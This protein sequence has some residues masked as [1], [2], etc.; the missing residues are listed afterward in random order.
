MKFKKKEVHIVLEFRWILLLC[1]MKNLYLCIL[2][3]FVWS[4]AAQ[5][6]KRVAA[7]N[8]TEPLKID[9]V[10]DEKVYSQAQPAQDFFQLQPYNGSPSFQKSEVKFFYD[11][12]SIYVGAMLSDT[13]PDSIFNFMTQ[14][15]NIGMSDYF[16]VYFDPYNKG[17]LAF[18]FFIT[19]AGVQTDIKAT[20]NEGD[21]E[22]ENWNAVWESK[23]RIVENGWI[24]EMKI[25]Y[26]ALRF[27]KN[28]E[29]LWGLN[30]FRNIRRHNSNNSWNFIDRK[31]SGFIHQ[32]G[33]L[34]GIKNIKS[35]VRLSFTP[36]AASYYEPQNSQNKTIFKGGMDVKYGLNDAFTLDMMLIPDFG[37]I[38]SDDQELN[39]SPYEIHYNE[40]RQFFTEGTELFQ[41]AELFYSRRIG[42]RPI[43]ADDLQLDEN[44]KLL[45]SPSETQLV[46]ATK[47][48]GRTKKG[49]GIGVLNAMSLPSLSKIEDINTGMIREEITQPFTN[50]NVM[51]VDQSLKNNSYVSLINTNLSMWDNP[52]S[53]NVSGTQFE[54]RDKTL[55]YALSGRAAFS[56]R[57]VGQHENGYAAKLSFQKNKGK[58]F[59]GIEHSVI[60]DKYNPND[61][62]YLQF[63]NNMSSGG[64]IYYHML[65]PN[66]VF[67]EW[68]IDAWFNYDRLYHPSVF[69]NIK[70][71]Y[72]YGARFTNNQ[73]LSIDGSFT[74]VKKDFYEP[75]AD[76]WFFERPAEWKN[77]IVF[78]TDPRKK[79]RVELGNEIVW[80]PFSEMFQQ[81][82]HT[83]LSLR[84][85]QRVNVSYQLGYQFRK[86]ERGFTNIDDNDQITFAKRDVST[87]LNTLDLDFVMNNKM[88]ITWRT[89]HYWSAVENKEFFL[90][91]NDGS[92]TD[93]SVSENFDMNYNA[94]N[95]DILYRWVFMPGSE[96]S[97]AWK[98]STYLMDST[99]VYQIFENLNH[100]WHNQIHSISLKVLFYIDY[101][102]FRK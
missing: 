77:E 83:E 74:G 62:G 72:D 14:R 15:D 6:K 17:Q 101:N 39:L 69:T 42:A 5:T 78:N 27:P 76:G 86:S 99:P 36:Y 70:T 55:T 32:Q 2:F 29:N 23:T 34:E 57:G 1:V 37:Q 65:E 84:V 35:P 85:G 61:M 19:P 79:F 9:A 96:L 60:S 7:L 100:S 52:F 49:L 54:F 81:Q 43:F 97:V 38:Q 47:I 16:G 63:N 80:Q 22:D 12:T 46:N 59:F 10:L 31:I 33:E 4:A 26:S 8:I 87:T 66:G 93:R 48:S 75:R 51:V 68:N 82:Y 58:F 3:A 18:G 30:M 25:P 56:S 90:L 71:G 91:K 11:Q 94:F 44:D 50:Y 88:G 45:Y 98:T 67:R 89:R 64:W 28:S 53:A 95:I 13:H 21:S 102:Y 92:L 20:K 40:K 73:H 41:R 24:V